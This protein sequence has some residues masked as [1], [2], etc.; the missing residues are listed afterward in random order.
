LNVPPRR[1]NEIVLKKRGITVDTAL[2]L[3]R[4]F[5]TSAE[6]WAGLQAD[7]D[8]RLARHE[9]ERQIKRDVHPFG[10]GI[11]DHLNL[12]TR[13]AKSAKKESICPLWA[14]LVSHFAAFGLRG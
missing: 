12:I 5:A 7:Y 14:D 11:K 2:R 1:I 3:A 9:R 13:R 10:E 8:L 4:Y 6:M